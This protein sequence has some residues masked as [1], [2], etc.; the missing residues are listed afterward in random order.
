MPHYQL[1]NIFNKRGLVIYEYTII[2]FY[3]DTM[4]RFADTAI[5][6]NPEEAEQ[7][8][9]NKNCGVSICGI[10]EGLHHCVDAHEFVQTG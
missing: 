2:G 1:W 5:A 7:Y 6:A 9:L 10:I 4:Q 8:I 3:A